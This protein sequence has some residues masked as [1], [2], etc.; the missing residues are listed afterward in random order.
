VAGHNDRIGGFIFSG[1][2]HIEIRP[3]RGKSAVLDF[4][5]KTVNH[6][7]WFGSRKSMR[8]METAMSRLRKATNPGSLIFLLSDFRDMNKTATS[9]LANIARQND[10][11]LIHVSDPIESELPKSGT[12]RVSD[13]DNEISL[14]TADKKVRAKYHQRFVDH[15]E[16]L[17]T[18]CRQHRMHFLNISTNDDVLE[19]LQSGLSIRSSTTSKFDS[20]DNG[21]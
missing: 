21:K 16:S 8:N 17:R 2:D 12:Y 5:G 14:N 3:R 1:D 9:H 18:L 20:S 11:V 19:S 13:G 4:I 7:A 6:T 10:V 15:V